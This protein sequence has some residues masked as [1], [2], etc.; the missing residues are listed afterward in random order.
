[1]IHTKN[2]SFKLRPAE[3]FRIFL[4]RAFCLTFLSFVVCG[5]NAR[6]QSQALNGQIE[7]VVTDAGGAAIPNA[8][9]TVTNIE[10]G[11]VR[12]VN[13]DDNGVYRAPLLPLGV[14]TVVVEAA[15]FKRLSRSGVT[16]TTGQIA[17]VDLRLETGAVTEEVTVTADAPVADLGKIDVGRVMNER[18]VKN[19]P[20][21]SRNPYNFSLLQANVTGR[22]N[23]EFGVPRINANGFA[24]RT[25]YQLDG[26]NNTQTDRAGIR[27]MPLSEIF[28]SEVQLVTNGFAAE[29]GNTPGLIM[30]AVTPSGT[31]QFHGNASYRF[32]RTPFSARPF[33]FAGA[34][35]PP[36]IVDDVAGAV[37]GPLVKDRWHFFTGYEHVKRDLGGEPARAL[38]IT[39]ANKTALIAAGLPAAAFP[40]N[41]PA[42]QK[43][44]FFIVRTDVQLDSGNRLA[45][46][47]NLFR[48]T[49]PDNIAGGLNT[50]ERSIDFVDASDS[51]GIQAISVFSPTA[52]NELRYQYAR[53][54]SQ[55]L[56]NKNSGK[57]LTIVIAGIAN[58]GAPT[59]DP[60][61]P[62]QT[63]NQ[64]LDNFTLT[65]GKH[66]LKFGGGFNFV[67]DSR[68]SGV[69]AQY[70]F[71]SIAAY[72]AAKNGSAPAGY[73]TYQETIGNPEIDYNTEFYHL[74]AQ[75]DWK[76]TPRLK[77]NYGVRYDLYNLPRANRNSPLALSQDFK[78]DKNNFA[79]RLGIV[80]G[81]R[82]GDR[83]T[84]IRAS[85]G[86]Y[87][88]Q[89][90]IDV[91]RRALQ[92]NG[93]PTFLNYSFNPTSPGAPRFP[94]TLGTLPPG[95]ATPRQSVTGVSPD[96]VNL[97]VL[98]TNV[99]VE[100]ALSQNFS[101]TV[102]AIHSRGNHIPI[103]R[104]IN[105]INPVSTLADGR[106][107]FDTVINANT[108]LYPNFNNVLLAES[109]GNSNYDAGTFQL[110]K[111]FANGYQFSANYTWSHSIDD[112]PEQNL[113]AVTDFVL[114]D[115]TNRKR[116]RGDSVAD[117]RHTFVLSF[118]GRP[119]FSVDNPFLK[120]LIDDNQIGVIATA[121]NGETFNITSNLD[122]NADG[123]A[124]SD[125]PLFIGRNTG[126]TPNQVN[127][128]FR[129]T[130]YLTFTERFNAEIIAEFVNVFNRRSVYQINS[131][132]TTNADGGLAAPL[133]DFSLRNPT[134]LDARQFQLGFKFNF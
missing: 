106:P 116:D 9:V 117:Q 13:S 107:K 76:V 29:F 114:S 55:N 70:T 8:K 86:L 72:V 90:L 96:F 54:K 49:S 53:R 105:P 74:F 59:N 62:L 34:N 131:V 33:F 24:R 63:S 11:V 94:T 52:L 84:V 18:E 2:M 50:F 103:Y 119:T 65:R 104:N 16:L 30:N 20:L 64:I 3:D 133:P 69:F 77:I 42:Q 23:S 67:E 110:T 28:V 45:G 100:Q 92:G 83:P 58:F 46:R 43:V 40:A 78:I 7:G 22:P 44:D 19:L 130:R 82:G 12:T 25:N 79:P 21:V 51:V 6:A 98:H 123:V 102:G 31:N 132:V 85:A 113:V 97:A 129:F 125:R 109:V 39:E 1:M 10:T 120:R 68:V 101:L 95:V 4:L 14:Y 56:P 38:T 5:Q 93:S 17:T 32:R 81:I 37:G 112:A 111:R 36:A 127:V 91:Y 122:L 66:T 121:N 27:L 35:K 134:A 128:D 87:Y 73:T 60:L 124:G 75:D 15:S 80:Y 57:G 126:R 89:P 41:I 26:N 47:Y 115:P 88:D 108:R 61:Q 118:V 48:N 99:Q 71:P